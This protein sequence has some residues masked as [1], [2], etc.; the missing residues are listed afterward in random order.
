M[1]GWMLLGASKV[2]DSGVW[3]RREGEREWERGQ[4]ECWFHRKAQKKHTHTHTHPHTTMQ[5]L[6]E[7]VVEK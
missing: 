2:R 7:L 4:T 3:Y 6:V 1:D 5:G